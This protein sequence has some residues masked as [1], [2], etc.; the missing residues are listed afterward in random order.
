MGFFDFLKKDKTYESFAAFSDEAFGQMPLQEAVAF[1]LN[2][3]ENVDNHW[4]AEW[5]ATSAFSTASDDWA[6]EELFATRAHPF[7]LEAEGDEKT[8]HARFKDYVER[9]FKHCRYASALRGKAAIALGFVDGDLEL[10]Y[11]NLSY[12]NKRP[13]N[14]AL[15]SDLSSDNLRE[16]EEAANRAAERFQLLELDNADTVAEKIQKI[17]EDVLAGKAAHKGYTKLSDVAFDLGAL[18]GFTFVQGRN[19][20]WM[21]L[22]ENAKHFDAMIVSPDESY[23]IPVLSLLY[24]ILHEQN[25][26]ENGKNE[27]NL[28]KLWNSS[29][30]EELL[31]RN[32]KCLPLV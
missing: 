19:W 27:I 4:S 22:G 2:L 32:K 18:Y 3:Y 17:V 28:L 13:S 15:L 1:N 26:D 25:P 5:V 20:S 23:C 12:A 11:Q 31:I 9:Y 8:I 30:K 16:L 10:V 6:C 21:L 24:R 7:V 14:Y 29:K